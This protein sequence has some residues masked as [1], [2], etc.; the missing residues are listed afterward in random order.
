MAFQP[1]F[2]HTPDQTYMWRKYWGSPRNRILSN[3]IDA[4]RLFTR[5]MDWPK[6]TFSIET[7]TTVEIKCG[8]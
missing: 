5:P 1:M 4:I 2:C 3:P 6:N 8:A 7:K